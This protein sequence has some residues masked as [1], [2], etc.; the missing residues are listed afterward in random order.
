MTDEDVNALSQEEE[1][2][3]DIGG[4]CGKAWLTLQAVIMTQFMIRGLI[5][6]SRN[7]KGIT[8]VKLLLCF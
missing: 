5:Y 4:I 6:Y 1:H 2:N 8:K 7:Q 3:M